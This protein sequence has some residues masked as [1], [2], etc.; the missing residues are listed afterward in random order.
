[1]TMA[2]NGKMPTINGKTTSE[3][4]HRPKRATGFRRAAAADSEPPVIYSDFYGPAYQFSN[5]LSI[6]FPWRSPTNKVI[7]TYKD[8][9]FTRDHGAYSWL[10][11]LQEYFKVTQRKARSTRRPWVSA[12]DV[13]NFIPWR[14][15]T[16]L[17]R[18]LSDQRLLA[19]GP[20]PPKALADLSKVGFDLS[21]VGIGLATVGGNLLKMA[22]EL[23]GKVGGELSKV[24][25]ELSKVGG[26][27][28]KVGGDLSDKVGGE[29]SKVGGDLSKLLGELSK[30]G[31]DLSN[32]VGAELSNQVGDDLAKLLGDLS[33][34][35]GDLSKVGGD[36]S[37]KVGG[38][39]SKVGGDLSKVGGELSKVGGD[40]SSN[41]GGNNAGVDLSK[42]GG[43]LSKVGGEL[44]GF[45]GYTVIKNFASPENQFVTSRPD[46]ADFN[47]SEPWSP[48]NLGGKRDKPDKGRK[49]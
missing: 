3:N 22:N 9:K 17:L 16:K 28:S 29:L 48:Q 44:G 13:D 1:M 20:P 21:Q 6:Y 27:L 36:L 24:G 43:D 30:V 15:E 49:R 7:Q 25:G 4:G 10:S 31:G 2:I 45:Y 34:V 19:L 42:V 12:P 37:S 26:D 39:L 46:R 38:D 33:K 8:Y 41:G 47:N 18:T 11:F 5:G 40:L 23:P 14:L 35:G 32:K